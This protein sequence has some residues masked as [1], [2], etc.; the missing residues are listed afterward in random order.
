[1]QISVQPDWPLSLADDAPIWINVRQRRRPADSGGGGSGSSRTFR[2]RISPLRTPASAPQV[3][4]EVADQ[5]DGD[6]ETATVKLTLS[7]LEPGRLCVR[8]AFGEAVHLATF[9]SPQTTL[10][11]LHQGK[12]VNSIDVTPGGIGVSS[13]AAGRLLV[14]DSATGEPRRRL[15]GHT[16]DVYTCR[17]FPSGIVA[18]S[19]GADC[20]IRV[21]ACDTGACA[22]VIVGHV[23]GVVGLAPIERGRNLVSA[24]RDGVVRLWD[25]GQQRCLASYGEAAS[26]PDPVNSLCLVTP[27]PQLLPAEAA[28]A[29]DREIGT[30]G[31]A[32]LAGHESGWL[33]CY[34]LAG[35]RRA[36][37]R[38]HQPSAVNFVCS[39]PTPDAAL[40][41]VGCADGR[42]L[43]L[44][45]NRLQTTSESLE[46]VAD[47]DHVGEE[48]RLLMLGPL[49]CG[50]FL[51]RPDRLAVGAQN[52]ACALLSLAPS[53]QPEIL[54]Q[55]TGPDCD[56]V[57][58]LAWD[59]SHL[60]TGCRDGRVRKYRC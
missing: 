8:Y 2:A 55:L 52:G 6:G 45:F 53:Q 7:L 9:Q 35:Q 60:Y 41:A 42:L 51:R 10:D 36:V 49:L 26:P 4:A 37:W 47:V 12:A 11:G 29:S 44:R 59:A 48:Q 34:G 13:D 50:V 23:G 16:G 46:E 21:W 27:G 40:A 25:V 54:M 3:T 58:C 39:A 30:A 38:S 33:V 15:E 43:A 22:A 14:W 5:Q 32:A 57:Y 17:F 24:G 1:V 31:K 19:G 28:P 18:M 56:P 20:R